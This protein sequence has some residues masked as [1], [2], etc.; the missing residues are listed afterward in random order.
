MNV[1]S[2]SSGPETRLRASSPGSPL[3]GRRGAP[4]RPEATLGQLLSQEEGGQRCPRA[5]RGHTRSAPVPGGGRVDVPPRAPRPHSVSS[6]PRRREGRGAP[7]RPEATLGQLQSQE[8]GGTRPFS[9]VRILVLSV[10]FLRDITCRRAA[11]GGEPCKCG[12]DQ[13]PCV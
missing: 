9:P 4:A 12:E 13:K 7:A 1:T 8:E 5:P 6:S 10:L 3:R 11:H 2:G